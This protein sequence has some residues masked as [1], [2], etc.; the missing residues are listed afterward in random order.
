MARTVESHMRARSDALAGQLDDLIA[1]AGELLE[2]LNDQRSEATSTLRS[3]ATRNIENARR[4]LASLKRHVPE[5]TAEAAR[6]ASGFARRNPWTAV[7]V[8]TLIAAS[9]GALLYMSLSDD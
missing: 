8:G 9:V 2:N 1:S 3:R 4:G 7:A 5:G 6:I